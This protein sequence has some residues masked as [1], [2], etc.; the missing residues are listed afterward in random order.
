M[1]EHVGRADRTAR[2]VLNP[3]VRPDLTDLYEITM[4]YSYWKVGRHEEP[5]VFDLF[6]RSNPFGGEYTIFAGLEDVLAFLES[7]SFPT[8]SINYLRE[9]L[10]PGADPGFWEYLSHLN[11]PNVRVFAIPEGSVVFPSMHLLRLEGPLGIVQL[12]E[13]TL[14][15]LTNFASL[16]TTNAAR[17]RLAA[18]KDKR[19][20]EFGL[21]RAQ[22]PD[23]AISASRYAYLGGFDGT[24]NVVAG[25]I[26]NIPVYG[27]HAHSFMQ[28]F[29]GF[30]DL[31]ENKYLKLKDGSQ[32][33]FVERVLWHREKLGYL[34]TK[35]SELAAFVCYA[36]CFPTSFLA[37]VDT[38]DTVRSGIP[39]FL[40][41]ALALADFD[42][43]AK[44]IRLDSGDLALL[45]G[46]ARNMFQQTSKEYGSGY[47]DVL[48][49]LQIVA[50]N[51]I[52]E[53]TIQSL[54]AQGHSIDVF[55]IGT[56]LVTCN[57]QGALRCVYKLVELRGQARIKISEDVKKVIVHESY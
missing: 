27:T 37:L 14:L 18:G 43:W 25:Q 50:S 15:N 44:G 56:S 29:S 42:Y 35:E 10:L 30:D 1:Q 57:R 16:M 3:Y 49:S 38:Y 36:I 17:H 9:N 6:F 48:D 55:G 11:C 34:H 52:D 24:S 53:E 51:N 22:G 39:N 31:G 26:F 23:G 33:N 47:N 28:S 12:L 41:V 5:A 19:L 20:I 4:A 45:S 13:A 54:N 7:C 32:V 2:G 21:R 40:C 46:I 8:A